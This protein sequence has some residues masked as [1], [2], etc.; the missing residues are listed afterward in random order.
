MDTGQ[1]KEVGLG[2][3]GVNVEEGIG[4]ELALVGVASEHAEEITDA[5]F[6]VEVDIALVLDRG[7]GQPGAALGRGSTCEVGT[8]ELVGLLDVE[9]LFAIT[10]VESPGHDSCSIIATSG[11]GNNN[12]AA[13]APIDGLRGVHLT[14]EVDLDVA[15]LYRWR[16]DAE[17]VLVKS[18]A[19]EAVGHGSIDLNIGLVALFNTGI[20][21]SNLADSNGFTFAEKSIFG[22]GDQHSKDVLGSARRSTSPID[23]VD[24]SAGR[25]NIVDPVAVL[26]GSRTALIDS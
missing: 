16:G 23:L 21:S 14:F 15:C 7:H 18:L 4:V 5:D 17:L 1:L 20:D 8:S 3:V 19:D 26:D 25:S 13:G 2:G 24:E 11:N 12:I 10:A 6:S 22:V 9:T